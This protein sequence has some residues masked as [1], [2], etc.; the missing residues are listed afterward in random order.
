MDTTTIDGLAFHHNSGYSGEVLVSRPGDRELG[1]ARTTFRDIAAAALAEAG[2]P[3][4][5][6]ADRAILRI[7]VA[8][9]REFVGRRIIDD[10]IGV[11]EQLTGTEALAGAGTSSQERRL[12][13][14]REWA[15]T[16]A[17]GKPG[18]PHR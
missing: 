9:L 17:S 6:Q 15:G 8:A 11:L 2:E 5:L 13:Q 1:W 7:P 10:E 3:L 4:T 12:E 14:V 18:R 16:P